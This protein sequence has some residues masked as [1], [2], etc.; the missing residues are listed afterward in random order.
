M[1]NVFAKVP[2]NTSPFNNNIFEN[3]NDVY[4]VNVSER[5]VTQL[6]M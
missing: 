6:R 2:I 1:S 3:R 5:Q 4:L